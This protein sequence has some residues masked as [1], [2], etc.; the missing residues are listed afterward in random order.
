MVILGWGTT[1]NVFE[2]PTTLKRPNIKIY[3]MSSGEATTPLWKCQG[4]KSKKAILDFGP[5]DLNYSCPHYC[6]LCCH[7]LHWRRLL[8]HLSS[9]LF[10]FFAVSLLRCSFLH[11]PSFSLFFSSLFV[12][13]AVC[14]IH[15]SFLC[16]S[17]SSSFVLFTVCLLR[18][19][20][21]VI[22]RDCDL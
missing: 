9:S 20:Y 13:F 1:L 5:R 6:C 4:Q 7:C 16:C 17:F 19:W 11:C 10:V 15:C 8:R 18:H 2:S 14:F 22:K 21:R 12:F 3:L